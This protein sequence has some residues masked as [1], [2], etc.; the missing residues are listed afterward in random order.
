VPY[1]EKNPS[2]LLHDPEFRKLNPK[3]SKTVDPSVQ[4]NN[5][6]MAQGSPDLV[7]ELT[8]YIASDKQALAWLR[9][10]PD[11][12]GM[13]VNKNFEGDKW[14]VPNASFQL[15]DDYI[16]K[17]STADDKCSAKPVL[18]QESQYVYNMLA[19]AVALVDRQPQSY[20]VC[21]PVGQSGRVWAWGRP[22]HQPMGQRTMIAITDYAHAEQFQLPEAALRNGGGKFVAPTAR[23]LAA[24]LQVA[25][26]NPKT[27]TYLA[28]MSSKNKAAYPGMMVVNAAA[29]TDGLSKDDAA[30]YAEMIK[31]MA[32]KGQ[33][34]GDAS[35]QLPP[36]YLALPSKLRQQALAAARH[37]LSQDGHG[38]L[39]TPPPPDPT[40]TTPT[41]S[42]PNSVPPPTQQNPGGSQP[43][44]PTP[45]G[46]PSTTTPTATPPVVSDP[47]LT[48]AQSSG[49]SKNLL[50][51]LLGI[52]GAGLVL[53]PLLMLT[54]SAARRGGYRIA[55]R[56][57]LSRLPWRRG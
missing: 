43:T 45:T 40:A 56:D 35:G 20:N 33:V 14:P 21:A 26:F 30:R 9:G 48:Q 22:A 50:P 16:D 5:P 54:S 29:P 25:H 24:A 1:L 47:V 4:I 41:N 46:G 39:P 18:E 44:G 36:G 37:V 31:W 19:A 6:V 23:S 13:V 11:P 55:M 8:R 2:D 28:N 7:Y 57:A 34:Y 17:H 42:T 32:T 27:K 53:T 51:I 12:W 49:L 3:V 38:A 52:G 10:R 15:R